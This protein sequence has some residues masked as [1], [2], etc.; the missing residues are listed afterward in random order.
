MT[1][2]HAFP[3]NKSFLSLPDGIL[4]DQVTSAG[5]SV[6]RK[7]GSELQFFYADPKQKQPIAI[8]GYMSALDL[9][10]P[11]LLILPYTKAL[12]LALLWQSDPKLV[13]VAGFGGGRIP[14][15]FHR[16][17]PEC[18]IESTDVDP[19]AAVI[20][21]RFFDI[22]YDERQL[23]TIMDGKC[24]LETMA[25]KRHYDLIF[26]DVFDDSCETARHFQTEDF[27]ELCSL[28]L[29]RTG[30]MAM[31]VV[32]EGDDVHELER[33]FATRFRSVYRYELPGTLILYGVRSPFLPI[34]SCHLRA[35]QVT[36]ELHLPLPLEP[37]VRQLYPISSS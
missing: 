9:Y 33:L 24:Y 2:L 35:Q 5:R 8:T 13:Y 25:E 4:W 22:R 26:L 32:A 30:V 37:L 16:Y 20:A 36:E 14:W 11:S 34:S 27:F 1:D 3:S 31:N 28:H 23:L 21:E 18:R 15:M 12:L 7:E 29:S 6:V 19:A 10:D 17:L